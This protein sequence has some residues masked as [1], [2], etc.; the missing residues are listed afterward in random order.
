MIDG[1]IPISAR[2]LLPEIPLGVSVY[3][4]HASDKEAT[5]LLA[6]DQKL[7]AAAHRKLIESEQFRLLIRKG[8]RDAYQTY[9]RE[10]LDHWI[11]RDLLP[12]HAQTA[13]L[14]EVIR[15]VLSDAFVEG[16]TETIL[17]NV[18]TWGERLATWGRNS[19]MSASDLTKILHH[20]Y[21]TFTHSANVSFYATLLATRLGFSPSEI[22]DIAVGGMLHDLGKLDIEER[23]L[24]KPDKLD[25]NEYRVIKTHPL[26]GYRRLCEQPGVT[27]IQILM[28]Y[29][30]HERMDGRGYPVGL[31]GDHLHD[32]AR[33][34]SI[35][36]VYEA[37]TSERP[38]RQAMVPLA[39][40]GL[41][42]REIDKAFDGEFFRCWKALI[43]ERT[44]N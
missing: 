24:N 43:S 25:D 23:I 36:D 20:D 27:E 34:C 28:T 41:M 21:G 13:V 18:N 38:Y 4:R 10:N 1:L 17:S 2:T 35:V 39:A 11:D 30:H 15:G 7:A 31:P 44:D 12:P 37:L 19:G 32:T 6:S 26:L 9:L 42:E 40:L 16:T 8:D 33:L 5:L 29:Q 14:S 22:R 3:F